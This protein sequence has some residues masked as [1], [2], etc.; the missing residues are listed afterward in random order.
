MQTWTFKKEGANGSGED[1]EAYV[2]LIEKSVERM[3]RTFFFIIL[4]HMYKLM[5][6]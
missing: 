6:I 1:C 2:V 5:E 3:T 4:V